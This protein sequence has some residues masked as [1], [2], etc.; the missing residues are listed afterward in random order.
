MVI[1]SSALIAILLGEREWRELAR[2]IDRDPTRLV[3]SVSVLEASLVSFARLGADGLDE[4]DL[5][6]NRIACHTR[7]FTAEDIP[8]ARQAFVRFGKGRHPA[9]LNFGDCF[10][11]ALSKRSGERLLYKGHDF[12][13]TDV[14]GVDY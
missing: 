12:A 10:S 6:L 1:D 8:L 3:S 13:L 14:D 9:A 2:A 5:L 4:L 7:A 11:Y